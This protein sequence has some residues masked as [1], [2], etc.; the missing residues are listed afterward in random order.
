M[1]SA[2]LLAGFVMSLLSPSFPVVN[3]HRS[4]SSVQNCLA[5]SFEASRFLVLFGADCSV[6]AS[7][8]T[9][10]ASSVWMYN[11]DGLLCGLMYEELALRGAVQLLRVPR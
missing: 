7:E 1:N 11:T 4:L 2:L 9:V 3:M 10:S 5:E 8:C 6:G